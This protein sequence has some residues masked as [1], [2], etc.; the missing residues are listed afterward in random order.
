MDYKCIPVDEIFTIRPLWEALNKQHR[1]NSRSFYEHYEHQTFEKRCRKFFSLPKEAVDIEI[2]FD[3]NSSPAG[4]CVCTAIYRT[5]ELDSI[6]IKPEY[7]KMGVGTILA[8]NGLRWLEQKGC[9][10]ITVSVADGNERVFPFYESLGF[11]VRKTILQ[12][13]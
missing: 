6:Y 5:G 11:A 9:T 2:A 7:R 4:Y 1:D 8:K 10:V 3:E 13:I 12:K